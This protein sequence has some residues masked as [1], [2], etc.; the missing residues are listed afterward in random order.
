ML[1]IYTLTI[2]PSEVVK[3]E[4]FHHFMSTRATENSNSLHIMYKTVD[5]IDKCHTSVSIQQTYEGERNEAGERHGKG[6]AQLPN[7]DF[8]DGYYANG[9]RHGQVCMYSSDVLQQVIL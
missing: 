9:R 4:T 1:A 2:L 7:G 6:V 3:K 5:Y 8:Y